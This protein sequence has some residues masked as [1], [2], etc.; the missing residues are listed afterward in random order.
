MSRFKK[1]SSEAK[2]W[3]KKMREAREKKNPPKIMAPEAPDFIIEI[4][5]RHFPGKEFKVLTRDNDY[6]IE[7]LISETK[8]IIDAG[9]VT[10]RGES[11]EREVI[12]RDVRAFPASKLNARVEVENWCKR[13][14]NHIQNKKPVSK[15]VGIETQGGLQETMSKP[16]G[17]KKLPSELGSD[18]QFFFRER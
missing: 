15:A 13:I 18:K 3:A 12:E 11:K 17:G 7:I 2:A 14:Q 16:Q 6:F 1:G 9:V 8:R 10:P 5:T 4:I